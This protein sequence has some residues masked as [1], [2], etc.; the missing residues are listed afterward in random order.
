MSKIKILSRWG[1][2]KTRK[3]SI[4]REGLHHKILDYINA[5]VPALLILALAIV[6]YEFGFKPFWK[7]H[8]GVNFWLE[9]V[10]VV[11]ITLTGVRLLL[12][13]LVPRKLSARILAFTAFLFALFVTLYVLPQKAALSHTDTN[14]FFS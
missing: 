13:L 6:I 10:L 4:V 11:V 8:E 3:L 7:N 9:I 2:K 14:R 5:F 12:D 1:L